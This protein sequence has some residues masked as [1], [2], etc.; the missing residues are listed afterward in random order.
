MCLDG[1]FGNPEGGGGPGYGGKG[2][3]GSFLNIHS[4]HEFGQGSGL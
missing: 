4:L 1:K 2:E 3:T